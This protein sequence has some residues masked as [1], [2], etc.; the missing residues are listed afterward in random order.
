VAAHEI[1]GHTHLCFAHLG[2]P[3]D[4]SSSLCSNHPSTSRPHHHPRRYSAGERSQGATQ[5][6]V[7]PFQKHF[8]Q[9]L[10]TSARCSRLP[11]ETAMAL[12]CLRPAC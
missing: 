6:F 12:S 2:L 7:I 4:P 9:D 10:V 1:S 11:A 8:S 5:P 3:L